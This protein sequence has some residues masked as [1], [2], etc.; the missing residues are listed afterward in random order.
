MAWLAEKPTSVTNLNVQRCRLLAII[1]YNDP[2]TKVNT[3]CH[4]SVF[5]Y[6]NSSCQKTTLFF[7]DGSNILNF[8]ELKLSLL[9]SYRLHLQKNVSVHSIV[10]HR[11][12]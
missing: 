3:A 2:C 9:T 12:Y 5:Y 6:M 4:T 7:I 1:N 8:F 11:Y 10:V